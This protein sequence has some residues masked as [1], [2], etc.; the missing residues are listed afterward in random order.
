MMKC[1]RFPKRREHA[2]RNERRQV[3]EALGLLPERFEDGESKIL[4][5]A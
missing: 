4:A 1:A 3:I 2:G 5:H